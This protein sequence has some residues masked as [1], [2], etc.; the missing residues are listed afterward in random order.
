VPDSSLALVALAF[1][2]CLALAQDAAAQGWTVDL[3]AGQTEYSA[4]PASPQTA[5]AIAS[6]RHSQDRRNLQMALAAP[7]SSEDLFW[8]AASLGDR[9]ALGRGRVELGIDVAGQAHAQRDPTTGTGGW[10]ARGE[11]LPL[12]SVSVGPLIGEARTG[13]SRYAGKAGGESWSRGLHLSDL[14]VVAVP[15]PDVRL[16]TESRHVR[17]E[18]G[19]YTRVGVSGSFAF[20]RGTLWASVG[21]W[22]S[23][24]GEGNPSTGWGV[25][26][27]VP[28]VSDGHL[29]VNVRR[30]PFDP[31][32]L[33]PERTS[34]GVGFGYR[35]GGARTS[36]PASGPEYRGNGTVIL[37]VPISESSAPPF[38]AGDFNGWTPRRMDRHGA[39]WRLQLELPPGVYR[40]AFRGADG[41][42]FVPE[43]TP[44]RASDG[45]GGWAASFVVPGRHDG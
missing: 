11:L 18:E 42:W 34:W 4:L 29:W 25:G 7:L 41:E 24:L 36:P 39:H 40:Y 44:W 28:V 15:R 6:L 33:G 43:G 45:M 31:V 9:F 14:H 12:V 19:A 30:E 10:G 2:S 38:V 23:G 21:D 1:A 13:G 35:L 3:H 22:I 20:A 37:R 32:F 27:A 17:G 8:T 26:A 16:S 5:N